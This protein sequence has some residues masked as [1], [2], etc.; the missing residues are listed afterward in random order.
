MASTMEMATSVLARRNEAA[1]VPFRKV[2]IGK[3]SPTARNC[4]DNARFWTDRHSTHKIVRGY[5]ITDKIFPGS[6]SVYSHAVV[7]DENGKLFDITPIDERQLY[8]FVRHVGSDGEF[9][10]MKGVDGVHV[11][12]EDL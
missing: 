11:S 4:H 8:V 6:W 1:N 9:D 12:I 7:Q 10:A 5:L 3:W 2:E